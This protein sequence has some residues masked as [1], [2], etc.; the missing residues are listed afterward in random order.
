MKELRIQVPIQ[1]REIQEAAVIQGVQ[2]LQE[3]A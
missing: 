3:G 2:A 1:A